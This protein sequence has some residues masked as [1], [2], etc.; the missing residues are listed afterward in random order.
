[1]KDFL[2]WSISEAPVYVGAC[3]IVLFFVALYVAAFVSI[4]AANS[5]YWI[6]PFTILVLLPA[7]IL[8][9]EYRNFLEK[10]K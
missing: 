2:Q 9:N 5:G 4:I 10:R 6:V 7:Y 8:R 1:M 3:V